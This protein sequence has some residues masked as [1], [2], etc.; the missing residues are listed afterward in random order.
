ML[1]ETGLRSETRGSNYCQQSNSEMQTKRDYNLDEIRLNGEHNWLKVY[2]KIRVTAIREGLIF[3]PISRL[4]C[5][6]DEFLLRFQK[7]E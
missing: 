2:P 4:L 7:V 1:S 5:K 6:N 3:N